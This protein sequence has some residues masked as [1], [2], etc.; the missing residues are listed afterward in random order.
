MSAPDERAPRRV[1]LLHG[2]PACGKLTVAR[3]MVE[4]LDAVILHNHLTFNL[5]NNLFAIG[6]QRLLDLHRELRLVMLAHALAP[7]PAGATPVPD[8]IL[9]LVYAE[10]DSIANLAEIGSRVEASGA[11][12]LPFY[13]QC[14]EQTLLQRVA[15][16]EREK[17]GKLHNT[18]RL[19]ELL[20][21]KHY[22]PLPHPR[23]WGCGSE[24]RY[25]QRRRRGQRRCRSG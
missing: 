6:D 10:P 19:R 4:Q 15:A 2:P 20:A 14:A 11:E 5:A 24:C 18:A 25:C 13:L 3:C 7:T 8:I 12:L 16:V 23:R 1:I 22:P 9:T 21:E 17:E